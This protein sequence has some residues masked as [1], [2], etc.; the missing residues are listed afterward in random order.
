MF[1]RRKRRVDVRCLQ[2]VSHWGQGT[3]YMEVRKSTSFGGVDQ[4][5][6]EME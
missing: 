3:K 1:E 2:E 5:K 6:A 4:R